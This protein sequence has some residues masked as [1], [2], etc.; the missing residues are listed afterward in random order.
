MS[1]ALSFFY[2]G[3]VYCPLFLLEILRQP[4]EDL[5]YFTSPITMFMRISFDHNVKK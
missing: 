3:N 2:A 4:A 5:V 1:I